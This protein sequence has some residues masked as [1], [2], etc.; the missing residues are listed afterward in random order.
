MGCR[1]TS[2]TLACHYNALLNRVSTVFGITN[3]HL[4]V[5]RPQA[6][7]TT[8][9]RLQGVSFTELREAG[10]WESDKSLRVYLD[11]IASANI[12]PLCMHLRPMSDWLES[13]FHER[14]TLWKGLPAQIAHRENGSSPSGVWVGP[15]GNLHQNGTPSP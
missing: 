1:L 14:F 3:L 4:T 10:R 6:G 13:N 5:H 8:R 11:I 9:M 12:E 15:R 7:W 2:I